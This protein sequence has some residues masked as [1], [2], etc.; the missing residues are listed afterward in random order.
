MKIEDRLIN[1]IKQ[2]TNKKVTIE[3]M[4]LITSKF[5]MIID[6]NGELKQNIE[7]YGDDYSDEE[8]KHEINFKLLI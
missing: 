7:L 2:E 4:D 3:S 5:Y 1:I 8:L 6:E